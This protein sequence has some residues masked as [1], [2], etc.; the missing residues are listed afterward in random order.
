MLITDKNELK[1]YTS[2]KRMWQGIPGIERTKGGRL[3]ATW[4]SGG[5]TEQ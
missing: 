1:K 3:F 5:V 4:Y 2:V